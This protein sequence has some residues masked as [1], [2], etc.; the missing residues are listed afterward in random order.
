MKSQ[1]GLIADII[2]SNSKL[3]KSSDAFIMPLRNRPITIKHSK[4]LFFY[5]IYKLL[6]FHYLQINIDVRY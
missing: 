1:D 6:T 2:V 3:L 4:I 5:S